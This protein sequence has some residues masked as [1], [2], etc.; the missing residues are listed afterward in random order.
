[1]SIGILNGI[2]ANTYLQTENTAKGGKI[3]EGFSDKVMKCVGAGGQTVSMCS[4]A[5]MSYASPQTGESINIYKAE[6]YSADNPLYII[7]GLDANGNEFEQEIDA[8]KINP[9]LCSYN[10]L[11]VLNLETGHTSP[12]DYLHAVAVRDKAGA[13]SYF[14]KKN[15]IAYAKAV[16]G[17]HKTMGN[18]TSYLAYGEWI[19]SLLAYFSENVIR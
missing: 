1:M 12:K 7:K 11:M 17:D 15:Y 13:D 3:E 19:Q 6:N 10:E 14:E 5:L 8:G 4:D 2:G 16:M 9:N 18:W